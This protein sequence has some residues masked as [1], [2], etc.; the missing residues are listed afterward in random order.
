MEA[1]RKYYRLVE[2]T[3][4]NMQQNEKVSSESSS[5]LQWLGSPPDLP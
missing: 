4:V 5:P 2:E 3:A 1:F